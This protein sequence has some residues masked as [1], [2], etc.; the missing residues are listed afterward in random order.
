MKIILLVEGVTERL[1]LGAFLKRW[2]DPRLSKP[3]QIYLVRCGNDRNEIVKRAKEFLASPE[4]R[5]GD[6]RGVAGLLDLYGIDWIPPKISGVKGCYDW[7]VSAVEKDVDHDRFRMFCAVHELEAWILGQ[8]DVLPRP[9]RDAAPAKVFA[10]PEKVDFDTPPA[11]LLKQ[12]YVKHVGR[13][14]RKTTDGP[15]LFGNL[16]PEPV[17]LKCPY[18]KALLEGLLDLARSAGE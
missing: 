13:K 17:S 14:Y 1:V 5:R 2:L 7:V 16:E 3:I 4:M 8:P 10:Y 15:R 12:L 18:F 11:K 6:I 9:V